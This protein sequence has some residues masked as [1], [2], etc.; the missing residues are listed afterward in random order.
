MGMCLMGVWRSLAGVGG[1]LALLLAA[2]PV[3]A[4][5]DKAGGDNAERLRLDQ[6]AYGLL[7]FE[8]GQYAHLNDIM[9]LIGIDGTCGTAIRVDDGLCDSI[10]LFWLRRPA[11]GERFLLHRH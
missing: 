8:R 2:S 5:G 9:V 7:R 3:M 6:Q 1:L 4:G 11:G 10:R